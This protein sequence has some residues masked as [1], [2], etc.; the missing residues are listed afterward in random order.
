MRDQIEILSDAELDEVSGGRWFGG[1]ID[2]N[3]VERSLV[4]LNV[5]PLN[6]WAPETLR[7]S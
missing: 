6:R 4:Q 2:W 5:L 7:A 3:S 1:P